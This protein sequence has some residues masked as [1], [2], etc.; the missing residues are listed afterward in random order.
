MIHS[1]TPYRPLRQ[2]MRTDL[3]LVPQSFRGQAGLVVGDP[4]TESFHHLNEQEGALLQLLDGQ[5]SAHDVKVAFERRFAPHQ[6]SL[7]E[8]QHYVTDF[9]SK[10]LLQVSGQQMGAN[11]FRRSIRKRSKEAWARW[12]NPL[13]IRFRGIN[14]DKMLNAIAPFTSW[15]F[16]PWM[17]IAAVMLWLLAAMTILMDWTAF[18]SR[19]PVAQ[20]FF[21]RENWIGLACVV[22]FTKAIHELGHGVACKRYKSRC[23]ELGILFMIF[24]PTLYVNTSNSWKLS[25]KWQRIW[26]ALAGIYVELTLASMCTFLWVHSSS[27]LVQSVSLNVMAMCSLS[28]LIVNAN[29]LMKF[30][31]YYALSDLLEIPNLRSRSGD[32]ARD[33][34]MHRVLGMDAKKERH[35]AGRTKSWLLGYCVAC[36]IFGWILIIGIAAALNALFSKAGLDWVSTCWLTVSLTLMHFRPIRQMHARLKEQGVHSKQRIRLSVC[37][38]TLMLFLGGFLFV[39]VA[40]YSRGECSL[41]PQVVHAIHSPAT[42]WIDEFG[43]FN[44]QRVNADQPVLRIFD[45]D[46]ATKLEKTRGQLV[47]LQRELEVTRS[48]P[49]STPGF[50]FRSTQLR[51]RLEVTQ[52]ELTALEE[53]SDGLQAV[54][55]HHGVVIAKTVS[56]SGIDDPQKLEGLQEWSFHSNHAGTPVRDGQPLGYV[57]QQDRWVARLLVTEHKV[58]Q[59]E[60]GQPAEVA[61]PGYRNPFLSGRVASIA[62]Q[63]LQDSDDAMQE[64]DATFA[65][66]SHR[67][68]R[69]RANRQSDA[70]FDVLLVLDS[71]DQP[72][73]LWQTGLAKIRL[74]NRTMADQATDAVHQWLFSATPMDI[75]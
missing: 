29:P 69:E 60:V 35:A 32:Y 72:L 63:S 5:R 58:S 14:P 43:A 33:L 52:A 50:R 66:P 54:A 4:L 24:V 13:S 8:I 46:L 19:L 10:G 55:P 48:A 39:P 3:T 22:A 17:V 64:Q 53:Q 25:N 37:A 21:S 49:S 44:G 20:E 36:Y 74:S 26:I 2:A 23:H 70:T 27:E 16:S 11:L 42:G 41:E 73:K 31:G 62:R 1:A 38:A 47:S 9:G 59:L 18:Q 51:A 67:M 6:I 56:R 61:I 57:V 68:Q 34:F 28:A 65:S 12:K 75:R 40:N 15:L 7:H 45:P 71:V 30:D